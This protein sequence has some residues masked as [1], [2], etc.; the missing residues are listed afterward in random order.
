M[1]VLRAKDL[2]KKCAAHLFGD[3]ADDGC[4]SDSGNESGNEGE[5]TP[6]CHIADHHV[7]TK[8]ISSPHPPSSVETISLIS[9]P[10]D[11]QNLTQ[12]EVK[13]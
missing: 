7:S 8:N 6:P 5:R 10:P 13:P 12:H 1:H 3:E 11:V 4:D 2:P 9:P